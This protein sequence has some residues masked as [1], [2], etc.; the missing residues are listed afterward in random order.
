MLSAI[1]ATLLRLYGSI[2]DEGAVLDPEYYFRGYKKFVRATPDIILEAESILTEIDTIPRFHEI[3]ATQTAYSANDGRYWKLFVLRAYG[4]NVRRNLGKCPILA[5]VVE[6]DRSVL[7]A[8][9]SFLESGKIIPKHRGIFP[10]VLR[11]HLCLS[12]DREEGGESYLELDGKRFDYE[13]GRGL[14]WDDTFEHQVIN[15]IHQPRVALL[16]DIRRP[17]PRI[18]LRVLTFLV[19]KCGNGIA[20]L[21]RSRFTPLKIAR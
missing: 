5:S 4:F 8:A 11:Y 15:T 21:H 19:L 7:S 2:R 14:L 6:E 10:G 13:I 12:C 20:R 1:S 9:I 18:G 17:M 3:S 16:L